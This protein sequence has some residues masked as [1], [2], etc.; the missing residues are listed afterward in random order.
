[1]KNKRQM[2]RRL[3]IVGFFLF[4]MLIFAKNISTTEDAAT[5]GCHPGGYTITADASQI[6]AGEGESYSL[7][8]TATG[9][10]VVVDIY[11]GAMDNDLF[12]VSPANIVEDNSADDTDPAED[13]ITVVF[14]IQMPSTSGQYIL[15]ILS[16]G[17]TLD[18]GNT[19]LMNLD[20]EVTIGVVVRTPIELFFDHTE[21]YIGISIIIFLFI[22]L[23]VFQSNVNR[24][25]EFNRLYQQ[26]QMSKE[27]VKNLKTITSNFT[28]KLSNILHNLEVKQEE[29]PEIETETETEFLKDYIQRGMNISEPKTH[30]IYIAIAFILMTINLF[31]IMTNTMDFILG[32]PERIVSREFLDIANFQDFNIII[33][34][35][36]GSVGYVAGIIVLSGTYTGVPGQKLKIPIYLMFISWTFNLLYG[37]LVLI[38]ISA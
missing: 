10:D 34:I 18:G 11:P 23:V 17:P 7:E 33:H 29:L 32:Y 16:R 27:V 6:Q 30:G 21:M 14:E 38:P 28:S 35:V 22:G 37:I 20:I 13:S 8:V 36:L 12:V 26:K 24:K 3:F 15:R 25:N 5:L 2:K 9:P 4:I 19:A 31:L 1:M